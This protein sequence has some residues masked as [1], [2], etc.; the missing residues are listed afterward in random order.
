MRLTLV[1][2]GIKYFMADP[3]LF[4]QLRQMFGTLDRNS[5]DKHR[6]AAAVAITYVGNNSIVLLLAG[7]V[8]LVPIV[9]AYHRSVGGDDHYLE[10]IDLLELERLGIGSAG[11]PGQF[12]VHAEI[13]LEG[14]RSE[15]LVLILNLDPFLGLDRLMKTVGPAP[16]RHHAPGE[17]VD[18]DD[19]A[20]LHDVIHLPL[21]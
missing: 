9:L 20:V 17:L 18:D 19:L 4:Q 3:L 8:N 5:A 11:H 21:V 1:L 13:V 16:P 14:D 6:L 2:L 12:A 10:A 15:R 7:A